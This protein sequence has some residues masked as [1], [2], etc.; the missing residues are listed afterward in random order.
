MAPPLSVYRPAY[1]REIVKIPPDQ[2]RLAHD[3]LFGHKTPVAAVAAAV[4]VVTH[5]KIMPARHRARQTAVIVCAILVGRKRLDAR[6]L[7]CRRLRLD[8]DRM[9]VSAEHFGETQRRHERETRLD[10]V[11]FAR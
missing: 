1:S 11:V 7:H 2:K 10:V 4:A 8:Q 6:E 3:V 5:K 9:L